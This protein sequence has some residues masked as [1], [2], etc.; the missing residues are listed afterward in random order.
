[1]YMFTEILVCLLS[2]PQL[3]YDKLQQG[4]YLPYHCILSAQLNAQCLTGSP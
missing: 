2:L 4:S 1:M 3:V